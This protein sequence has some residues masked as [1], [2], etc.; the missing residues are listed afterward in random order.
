MNASP[1]LIKA[2]MVTVEIMGTDLSENAARVF[3][4]D[5]SKYP[6]PQVAAALVRC[7]QECRG[8]L[9]LADVISR[10]D[11]GRPGVEEAWALCPVG[12][13]QTVVW[14]DEM[15][16]A[17]MIADQSTDKIAARMAFK[18]AYTKMVT[19]ARANHIPVKWTVSLGHEVSGRDAPLLEAY[20]NHRLSH[21][22]VQ[23]LLPDTNIDTG[24]PLGLLSLDDLKQL[25]H[26][27]HDEQGDTTDGQ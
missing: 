9:T 19:E 18:E 8:R 25:S 4:E 13:A 17:F 5:L 14:S 12:E 23:N 6:E 26:D 21:E 11:D 2:V 7:R 27:K 1:E 15:C 16:K 20:N 24:Q 10:L 3:C 22:V